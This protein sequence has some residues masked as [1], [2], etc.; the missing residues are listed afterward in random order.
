LQVALVGWI[1]S[2]MAL[3]GGL[4]LWQDMPAD[5]SPALANILFMLALLTCPWLWRDK[6]LGI[7]LSQRIFL[8]MALVC[9]LPL[10]L[11]PRN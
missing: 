10:L 11:F 7:S 3:F 8:A 5:G 2:F 6:P 1:V 4:A 9:S